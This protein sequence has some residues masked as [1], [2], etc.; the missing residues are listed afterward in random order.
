MISAAIT[1]DSRDTY[2]DR[3]DVCHR[4]ECSQ[5]RPH[6]RGEPGVLDL[7]LLHAT[8]VG[9]LVP[10]CLD[11]TYMSAAFQTEDSSKRRPA[12]VDIQ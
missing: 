1:R 9:C 12:D 2:V 8:L 7:I 4:E 10:C 6:F 11:N 3:D 5:A